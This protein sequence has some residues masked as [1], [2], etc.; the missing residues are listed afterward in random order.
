MTITGG[1]GSGATA[2]ATLSGGTVTGITI[3]NPGTGYTSAPTVTISP[4]GDDVYTGTY[5][6]NGYTSVIPS[7]TNSP[8]AYLQSLVIISGTAEVSPTT[9]STGIPALV[10]LPDLTAFAA[11]SGSASGLTLDKITYHGTVP[12]LNG[13][14]TETITTDENQITTVT[15]T[16]P[17]GQGVTIGYLGQNG[18]AGTATI[19]NG[20]S[21]VI[22]A[23]EGS[24]VFLNLED[25]IA[26]TGGGTITINAGPN[27]EDVAAL[28]NLTTV[29]GD[30]TIS[31]GGNIALSTLTTGSASSGGEIAVTSTSGAIIFNEDGQNLNAGLTTLTQFNSAVSSAQTNDLARAQLNAT[32][33]I[34]AANLTNANLLAT[35]EGTL[36]QA[37][38]QLTL[39]KSLSA[40]MQSM[41]SSVATAQTA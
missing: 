15:I 29:G 9:T 8:P 11:A 35:Y 1:G 38:A 19:P 5:S 3:T 10:T 18:K 20:W 36:A 37:N 26:T 33:V 24:V 30:I 17:Q 2:T 40:A 16:A 31:A 13:V 32:Q 7:S 39:V 22:N 6:I 41:Q 4:P 34:A 28:G 23:T 25:T 27:V 14:G 21:L 12:L